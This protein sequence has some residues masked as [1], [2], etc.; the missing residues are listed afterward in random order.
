MH[1]FSE[2]FGQSVCDR[3]NG[4]GLFVVQVRFVFVGQFF[5]ADPCRDDKTADVVFASAIVWSNVV[6]QRSEILLAFPFPLLSQT[7]QSR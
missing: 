1:Q 3:L 4:D 7:V 2:R 5:G 6:C